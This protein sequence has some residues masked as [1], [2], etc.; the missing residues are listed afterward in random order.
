LTWLQHLLLW[1]LHWLLL[2]WLLLHWLLLHWLQQLYLLGSGCSQ[3]APIC[4]QVSGRSACI[5]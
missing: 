1:L 3:L 2:H 5:V 4:P